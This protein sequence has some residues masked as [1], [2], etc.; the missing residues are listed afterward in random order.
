MDRDPGSGARAI[1][2]RDRLL[3]A[4]LG[5]TSSFLQPEI[6]RHRELIAAQLEGKRILVTGA[7][8]SIGAATIRQ[9]AQ[10]RP[11]LVAATDLS[12]NNLVEMV[13]DV[14]SRPNLDLGDALKTYV[15]DF[16]SSLG[17]RFL[18]HVGPFDLVLH[19]AAMK[20]VR[21]E[22]DAFT[23]A[24]MLETN[25]LAVDRFL[26]AAKRMFPCEVFAIST[27]K[28]CR[29]ANF[30]G[31]SKRLM[32]AVVCWHSQH[33]GTI[34]DGGEA[35]LIRRVAITRF[36]NVAFS[37]GSLLHGFL[38]RIERRQPLAGP[39]D[40]RRY[41]ISD[42]EAGQLCL[43]TASLAEN[44]QIIVPQAS[45][46][47]GARRFDSLAAALL[48]AYGYEPRWYDGFEE[49]S[50]AVSSDL[51]AGRYPCC[52]AASGTSGEKQIEEFV[53]P[54]ERVSKSRF[55]VLDVIV[56]SP[57]PNAAT[58]HTVLEG[59]AAEVSFPDPDTS[60]ARIGA[61]LSQVVP[62]FQ[63]VERGRN[64]DQMA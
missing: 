31:A 58:L 45:S 30:M 15:V 42:E 19:F 35:A 29:P 64:L 59:L 56:D 49:A 61:L 26:G 25:V 38:R 22:R 2:D 7:A 60:H 9:I 5:R 33:P 50:R 47:V 44:A 51:A 39:S 1:P 10:Y 52:F 32:E 46:V 28:A 6:D 36:A 24:R 18:E 11:R 4:V 14:R 40:V 57:M 21:A 41:F 54:D 23:L 17:E 63:H 16:G 27:D 20:H 13:R 53:G 62:S 55:E 48:D 34:L 8:G 43:L 12:E 37:D 3:A